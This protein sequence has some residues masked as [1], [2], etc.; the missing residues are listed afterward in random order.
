MWSCGKISGLDLT[1]FTGLKSLDIRSTD[2]SFVN[3]AE[4]PPA[5]ITELRCNWTD[6]ELLD[7]SKYPNI[8][9]YGGPTHV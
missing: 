8:Q 3:I 6:A 7:F 1:E 2:A 9:V 5:A 4:N